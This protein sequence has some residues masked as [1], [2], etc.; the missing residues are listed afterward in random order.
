[1][2]SIKST[3]G[4]RTRRDEQTPASRE[5]KSWLKYQESDCKLQEQLAT[6]GEMY[7]RNHEAHCLLKMTLEQLEDALDSWL[8]KS[9][10]LNAAAR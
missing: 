9:R 7:K 3:S 4:T 10:M 5:P 2:N 8:F 6:E 1:M